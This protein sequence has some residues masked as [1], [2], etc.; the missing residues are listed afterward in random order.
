MKGTA[1]CDSVGCMNL[2]PMS[3]SPWTLIATMP[4]SAVDSWIATSLRFVR[5]SQPFLGRPLAI[6]RPMITETDTARMETM[7]A[8]REASHHP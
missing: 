3:V 5:P 8:E 2:S 4:A 7:P 1:I 6:I